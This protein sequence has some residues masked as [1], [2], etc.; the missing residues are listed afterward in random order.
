[1]KRETELRL[2]DA[3][4]ERA[5][6]R[7]PPT[8]GEDRLVPVDKYRDPARFQ[9]ERER[10]FRRSFNIV[11]HS[12]ELA[13]EGEFVT[14]DLVGTPTLLVRDKG[15][16]ARAFINVCRH[17]GATV[18]LRE[19]GQCK[20]FV[21]PYHAWTYG[22]DG[23]LASVRH[24]QGF[25]SL[26]IQSTRLAELPCVEAGGFLWVCPTPREDLSL[27]DEP[28]RVMLDE[29]V[30][31]GTEDCVVFARE[32]KVWR[33]NWKLIVDGG[34]ES[35]HFRVAH[36]QTV[37]PYFLDTGSIFEQ[38]GDHLRSVLPR[39]NIIELADRPRGEW[40]I[41]DSTH[42]LYNLFPNTSLLV[43][44]RHFDLICVTPLAPDETRIELTTLVPAPGPEG[45]SEKA[46]GYWSANQAFTKKTLYE[47][48]E[49]AEQIQRGLVTDAN[50][51]FRF[52]TFEDALSQWHAHIDG[53]LD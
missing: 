44:E 10:L 2:L 21:C 31:L 42:V 11:A 7:T 20:R 48:F 26:D 9:R 16:R 18:E 24:R 43:Q 5:R 32:H 8:A 14:R 22:T 37:G 4:I 33:A 25:P 23:A 40:S 47:D 27:N 12:S 13:A 34:I 6:A 36:R 17:R 49:L 41:R 1:M 30:S 39:A 53:K 52:A 28:T 38:H 19:R 15:G 35:Y 3:C 29:L 51:H 45:F 50:Q 46:R